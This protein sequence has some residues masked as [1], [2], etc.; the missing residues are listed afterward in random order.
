MW[1]EVN[2]EKKKVAWYVSLSFPLL[3]FLLCVMPPPVVSSPLVT[4]SCRRLTSSS[5]V[6]SF[7]YRPTLHY[8]LPSI[9]T[10]GNV[11]ALAF[12]VIALQN[13][14]TAIECL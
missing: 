10:D 4:Y 7:C 11:A 5:L 3:L 8:T 1:A 2:G 13:A 12:E 6:T 14:I 9:Y